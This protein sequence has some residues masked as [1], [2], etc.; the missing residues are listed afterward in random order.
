MKTSVHTGDIPLALFIND[1][2]L[3]IFASLNLHLKRTF[4]PI[5][6]M[7]TRQRVCVARIVKLQSYMFKLLAAAAVGLD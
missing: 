7:Q 5:H 3:S 4:F 1:T 6:Y 2:T